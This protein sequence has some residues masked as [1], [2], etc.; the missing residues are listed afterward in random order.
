[1]RRMRRVLA[2]IPTSLLVV[3][4]GAGWACVFGGGMRGVVA[5]LMLMSLVVLLGLACLLGSLIW[6][7]WKRRMTAPLA[8]TL[9]LAIFASWPVAWNFGWLRIA[10]PA[11]L[12]RTAPAASVRLPTNEP[13]RVAWGGDR[14]ATNYHVFSPDERWAYD[15]AIEPA[16][17]GSSRLEDYGCWDKPVVAPADGIVRVA[18]EGQ[19]DNVP[20]RLSND[21]D[22]PTGN[23]VA[24]ELPSTKTF[25]LVCHLK[26]GSIAV[27][28]GEA[29][30]EGRE[31]GRCG[32]SGNT[33]E[34]HVHI[35]HQRQDPARFRVGLAEGLPLYFRDHDGPA[36]PEGGFDALGRPK[37]PVVRHVR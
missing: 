7:V 14:L 23:F 33:S 3:A 6:F 32:N 11:S 31:I 19:P 26:K 2:W 28:E 4:L 8:C 22:N 13:M 17:S 16:F 34:P 15:L 37:G 27:H 1:M 25:L 20:G 30:T 24:I 12:A 29:V 5:W 18:R 21:L 36:M 35:H 9:A 10:Y